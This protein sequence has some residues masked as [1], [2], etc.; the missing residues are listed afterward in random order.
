MVWDDCP[1]RYLQVVSKRSVRHV[2]V[3]HVSV[4]HVPN[5]AEYFQKAMRARN[6]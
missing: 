4:R 2:S 1:M 3:R 5:G 6:F